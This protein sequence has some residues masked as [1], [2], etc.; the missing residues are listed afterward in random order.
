MACVTLGQVAPSVCWPFACLLSDPSIS[1]FALLCITEAES[2][3]I[4]FPGSLVNWLSPR[5][6]QR[7][8][9][10][11]DWRVG[12]R[13]KWGCSSLF[14]SVLG[15]ISRKGWVSSTGF[16]HFWS[17]V[18]WPPLELS[19]NRGV[20]NLLLLLDSLL[21]HHSGFPYEPFKH[22]CNLYSILNF[23]CWTWPG[24]FLDWYTL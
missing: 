10:E 16:S 11:G 7:E 9:A 21:S 15:W 5:F 22:L 1:Y 14:L 18:T 17:L 12:G 20:S 19:Q 13:K 4:H 6:G 2:C 8:A 23:L 3:K 24:L